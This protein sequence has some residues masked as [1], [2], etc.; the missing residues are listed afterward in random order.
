VLSSA[1]EA[2]VTLL[3]LTPHP[4]HSST[5]SWKEDS[6]DAG[7]ST[8]SVR[9]YGCYSLSWKDAQWSTDVHTLVPLDTTHFSAAIAACLLASDLK[10]RVE[11]WV[12]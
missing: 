2:G 5:G 7:L 6:F 8:R 1:L 11:S 3:T 9:E 12:S 10:A 4:S